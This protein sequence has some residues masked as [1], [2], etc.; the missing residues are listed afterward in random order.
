MIPVGYLAK[1][2]VTVPKALVSFLPGV[3]DVFS[4]SSCVND[5]FADYIDYW[6]HNGYWLFDS[7]EIIRELC[8]E[9]SIGLEGTLLFFYE[10]F[11]Q[12]FH[13]GSWR[14]FGP[15]PSM[16]TQVVLPAQKQ[17]EGFDVVTFWAGNAP[18]CS[19][20][21]CNN[22]GDELPINEHCLLQSIESAQRA[23]EDGAFEKGESGPYRI[24]AV[25]SVAWP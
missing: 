15:E 10:A 2:G 5:D 1:R 4:V 11:E 20:L 12:E 19:P 7:P 13:D 6:K 14:G 23:L 16:S 9:Q 21:S 25:N 24:Y 3:K 8:R 18:E 22:L 17:L